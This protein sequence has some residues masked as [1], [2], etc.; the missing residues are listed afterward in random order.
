MDEFHSQLL[1]NK[2]KNP[3]SFMKVHEGSIRV[4]LKKKKNAKNKRHFY[5]NKDL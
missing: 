4:K 5:E 1:R 2:Q 3:P